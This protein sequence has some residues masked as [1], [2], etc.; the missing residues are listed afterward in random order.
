M[1]EPKEVTIDEVTYKMYPLSPFKSSKILTR[2]LKLIG[3]PLGKLIGESQKDA[4][5]NGSLLDADV[6]PEIIGMALEALTERMEENAIEK[7]MKDLLP[8]DLI[9]FSVDGEDYKKIVNIESHMNKREKGLM[10]LFK[11]VKFS[12]EVNYSDFLG[13]IAELKG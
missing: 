11:L 8:T 13:E 1:R 6:N 5:G 7:L 3:R 2:I 10:H 9:T 12:L 4:K